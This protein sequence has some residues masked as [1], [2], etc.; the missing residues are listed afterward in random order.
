MKE[1]SDR[2]VE[3][4]SAALDQGGAEL[5]QSSNRIVYKG[6]AMIL[7]FMIV[8]LAINLYQ[9]KQVSEQMHL[10]VEESALKS[11]YAQTMRDAAR[12]RVTLLLMALYE[13]D[14]FVQDELFMSFDKQAGLF[15]EARARLDKMKLSELEQRAFELSLQDAQRG[16]AALNQVRDLIMENERTLELQHRAVDLI[17]DKVIPARFGV[18]SAMQQIQ[19]SQS[20][21]GKQALQV[22]EK[23]RMQT[24]MLLVA[25]GLMVLF[26]SLWIARQVVRQNSRVGESLRRAKERA[27]EAAAAKSNFLS[28]MSHE[29][30]TPMNG[31]LGMVELLRRTELNREQQEY[32]RTMEGSGKALLVIINDIL[33]L[34]KIEAGKLEL[35]QRNYTPKQMLEDVCRT[36]E[37]QAEDKGVSLH[38]DFSRVIP[39]YLMGDEARLRQIF[40]NLIGN[41]IKF[42]EQGEIVVSASLCSANEE[43]A[44][45]RFAVEDSGIGIPQEKQQTIFGDFAQAD[46]STTRRF[47]GTGLGLSI[48]RKLIAAMGGE[49]GLES[50]VGEG[51][52]FFFELSFPIPSQEPFVKEVKAEVPKHLAEGKRFLV[53]DDVKANLLVAQKMLEQCGGDVEVALHGGQAVEKISED[54]AFDVVLMDLHMPEMDGLDATRKIREMGLQIPVIVLTASVEEKERLAALAA[55]ADEVLHKPIQL[56]R[57]YEAMWKMMP[58]EARC[59]E[60]QGKVLEGGHLQEMRALF[61]EGFEELMAAY[62]GDLQQTMVQLSEIFGQQEWRGELERI[63]QLAHA[64]KSSSLSVGVGPV[65]DSARVVEHAAREQ[66]TGQLP[67]YHQTLQRVVAQAVSQLQQV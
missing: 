29:I 36:F 54:R 55:G 62:L 21:A 35:E 26:G 38:L 66:Q 15:M 11:Q 34:S 8:F 57:L 24:Y 56:Q 19:E 5:L 33:D 16:T 22:A 52:H 51:S 14:P 31:V 64:I 43:Q 60:P 27:E 39:Q 58:K 65:A 44:T 4:D 18:L 63:R 1:S 40:N 32:L 7:L 25:L 20:K 61:G 41:A 67:E 37:P 28:N 12:E 23:S 42:T 53:V 9:I 10:V 49:I 17:A 48:T 30:R 45:I 47:G 2:H 46:G 3:G 13:E 50:R 6:F 59:E